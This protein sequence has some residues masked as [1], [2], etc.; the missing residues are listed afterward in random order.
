MSYHTNTYC[1]D[2]V[3]KF[4]KESV[5]PTYGKLSRSEICSAIANIFY[6]FMALISSIMYKRL[7]SIQDKL[8]SWDILFA[9]V[10]VNEQKMLK[11]DADQMKD[12]EDNSKIMAQHEEISKTEILNDVKDFTDEPRLSNYEE[13]QEQN[14]VIEVI[15]KENKPPSHDVRKDSMSTASQLLVFQPQIQLIQQHQRPITLQQLD[16]SDYI[17]NKQALQI[18]KND[19][20][21]IK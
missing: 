14:N 2:Q 6:A 13:L 20:L 19:N 16:K 7:K 11:H 9:E 1:F 12:R 15:Q 18:F 3:S 5:L 8:V 17:Q 4:T 10:S 21:Q